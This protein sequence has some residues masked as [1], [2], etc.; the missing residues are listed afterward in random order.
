MN[1]MTDYMLGREL[2]PSIPGVPSFWKLKEEDLVQHALS[3]RDDKPVCGFDGEIKV[4]EER[5][6]E[7]T[8]NNKCKVCR[9]RT[10]DELTEAPPASWSG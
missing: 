2:P 3:P 4:S 7:S 8:S 1:A 10:G 5:W 9:V 6:Y